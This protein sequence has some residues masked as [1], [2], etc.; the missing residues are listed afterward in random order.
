[1]SPT[2]PDYQA[3]LQAVNDATNRLSD[4]VSQLNTSV[5]ALAQR[6]AAIAAVLAG[7]PTPEEVKKAAADLQSHATMLNSVSDSLDAVEARLDSLA[8]NPTEPAPPAEPVPPV[9]VPPV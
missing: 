4:E 2:S 7:S 3:G 1:M 6:D 9:D 5:E 8:A